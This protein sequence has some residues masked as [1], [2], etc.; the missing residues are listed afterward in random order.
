[1]KHNC[2]VGFDIGTTNIKAVVLHTNGIIGEILKESTPIIRKY[3]AMFFNLSAIEAIIKTFLDYLLSK[4]YIHGISFTSVGES[5][6]PVKN[7]KPMANALVWY[8]P[9]T[10]EMKKTFGKIIQRHSSQK[11]NVDTISSTLSIYKI[12]WMK[13]VMGISDPEWWLPLSSYF[14]Y[15]FTKQ[16]SWDFSQATRTMLLDFQNGNWDIKLLKQF[17]LE[18]KFPPLNALGT[19][20]GQDKQGISYSLGGHDHI[21]GLLCVYSIV[22][23]QPFIF[24]S[25]GTS[26]SI[27]T[28]TDP[29]KFSSLSDACAGIAFSREVF[30]ILKGIRFSGRFL[31]FIAHLSGNYDISTYYNK[32]NKKLLE[33]IDK[34]NEV[35]P[36]I[37]GGDFVA[38]EQPSTIS[39]INIPVEADGLNIIHSAYTYLGTM[40]RLIVEELSAYTNKTAIIVTSGSTTSNMLY[41]KYRSTI[42]NRPL[43]ILQTREISGTGAALCAATGLQDW[44]TIKAFVEKQSVTVIEPDHTLFP[45]LKMQSDSLVAFY[46]HNDIK[47]LFDMKICPKI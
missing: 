36:I 1:M 18:T 27:I 14:V 42:L 10:E 28:L 32:M 33:N 41:M 4:Y 43:H 21:A 23:K 3:K 34:L 38:C 46:R 29:E 2:Y 7:G 39:I 37:T 15:R 40:V 19:Y 5:V 12:L 17:N 13:S 6:V 26:E 45:N 47:N 31:E 20:M 8:D 35:F 44:K 22:G 9:I 30:Y 24:D 16:A 11:K 25:I